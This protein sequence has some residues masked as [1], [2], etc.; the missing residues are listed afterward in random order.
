MSG[1]ASDSFSHDYADGGGASQNAATSAPP[2][3]SSGTNFCENLDTFHAEFITQ[4]IDYPMDVS[5]PPPLQLQGGGSCPS[6][7][8]PPT[9]CGPPMSPSLPS[10]LDTYRH[11][12]LQEEQNQRYFK[13][14]SVTPPTSTPNFG[15][16]SSPATPNYPS[17]SYNQGFFPKKEFGSGQPEHG[18][19]EFYQPP[20]P[21]SFGPPPNT[22]PPTSTDFVYDQHENDQIVTTSSLSHALQG[23]MHS[24]SDRSVINTI[25][26]V[27][28]SPYSGQDDSG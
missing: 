2:N 8:S 14:E 19:S 11:P 10:F 7:G 20:A 13:Q 18:M 9:A 5:P 24:M 21:S 4:P 27:R 25:R 6:S 17:H 26:N 22:Y 28:R 16:G 3:T 1:T 15:A 23:V 12:T